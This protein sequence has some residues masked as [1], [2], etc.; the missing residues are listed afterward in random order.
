MQHSSPLA[1][2]L[3]IVALLCNLMAC[4]LLNPLPTEQGVLAEC[5]PQPFSVICAHRPKLASIHFL[6]S[7]VWFHQ[8]Q[9]LGY[10]QYPKK[11]DQWDAR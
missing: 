1:F 9:V 3:F 2:A 11:S 8:F 10:E 5:V 4:A 6:Q 7:R